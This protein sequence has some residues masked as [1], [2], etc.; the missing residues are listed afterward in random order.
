MRVVLSGATGLIGEALLPHLAQP[1]VLSRSASPSGLPADTE[2]GAWN[3]A[4]EVPSPS[5]LA[6]AEAIVHLAGEPVAS[7]RWTEEK[8]ARI[9]DS[10]VLGTR[11]LVEAL[12]TMAELP[13]VLVC[14]SAVGFY[15]D[16]GDEVLDDRSGPGDDFLADVCKAWEAEALAA[17]QLGVRVVCIRTGLV[18][19]RAGGA[20]PR[21]STP[22]KLGLGG[23]LGQGQQW[24]PWIHIEDHIRII[25]HALQDD[26]LRG[27][28]NAVS[29]KPV[30]NR[31]FT[32]TLAHVLHRPAVFAAPSF[33]LKLALGEMSQMVLASQRAIPS[34]LLARGFNFNYPTLEAALQQ[35][36]SEEDKAAA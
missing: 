18:L 10:R 1:R 16:R 11:H 14:A 9:R 22:F 17:E 12:S 24:M 15:G 23:K 36:F 29:P 5:L 31:V 26:A 4:R 35:L 30:T 34:A 13:R 32:E 21:M 3:P 28:V 19:S 27:P 7:G 6:G 2:V 8:K 20:L 33:A 25:L